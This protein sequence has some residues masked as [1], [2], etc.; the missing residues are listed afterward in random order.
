MHL[1]V[2]ETF[3]MQA[4]HTYNKLQT[5]GEYIDDTEV[6]TLQ[7]ELHMLNRMGMIVSWFTICYASV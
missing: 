7:D 3:F 5:L 2:L 6:S 4:D 1:Q